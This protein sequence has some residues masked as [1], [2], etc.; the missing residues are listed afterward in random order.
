MK[1]LS[2]VTLAAALPALSTLAA[3]VSFPPPTGLAHSKRQLLNLIDVSIDQVGAPL[4]ISNPGTFVCDPYSLSVGGKHPPFTLAAVAFPYDETNLANQTV[5]VDVGVVDEAGTTRWRPQVEEKK[6]FVIRAVDS[7]G[8]VAYSSE[9]WAEKAT[10]DNF[11]QCHDISPPS[12]FE[13]FVSVLWQVIFWALFGLGAF[14]I[15]AMIVGFCEGT[16]AAEE[17][18]GGAANGAEAHE[19]HP[20][21]AVAEEIQADGPGDAAREDARETSDASAPLLPRY[22]EVA[23]AGK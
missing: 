10:G 18:A 20:V 22:E 1:V 2:L 6:H 16:K 13:K 17:A 23:A 15:I 19:L 12:G 9:Q 5:L 3:P 7:A 21:A 4:Y 14:A 11:G 8:N